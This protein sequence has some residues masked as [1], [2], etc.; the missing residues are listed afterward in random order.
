M[1]N[2]GYR[3]IHPEIWDDP[4]FLDLD[5]NEKL[6]FIYMFSN[7]RTSLCGLYEISIK[8]IVFHTGLEEKYIKVTIGK[9]NALGK[10][11][12]NDNV[13]FVVNQ[14]KRHFSK[15][16][17]V[18]IRIRND[19]AAIHDCKPKSVCIEVYEDLVGYPYSIDTPINDNK[20]GI[21]TETH[22]IR[23]DKIRK[24]KIKENKII[25][26]VDKESSP[27]SFISDFIT[28]IR[29]Q[30]TND[31]QP[32][33]IDDLVDD[34]GETVVL[35]AATWYGQNNPRNMG[36]ALKSIETALRKGWDTKKK[37]TYKNSLKALEDYGNQTSNNAAA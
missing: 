16:P 11:L 24:D 36:H 26:D 9:F 13:Y 21:D 25:E 15:S 34:Y 5:T 35:E 12:N 2:A 30:F 7:A 27:P 4:F 23:K 10:I 32:Q 8:Q 37:D 33:M 31:K 28:A 6:L 20:E 18:L 3:Q 1:G 14:F 17:K 19:I 22:K 29:V